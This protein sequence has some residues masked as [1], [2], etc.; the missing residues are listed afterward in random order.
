M[1]TNFVP[2]AKKLSFC[3]NIRARTP[4][5]VSRARLVHSW[6]LLVYVATWASLPKGLSCFR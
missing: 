6:Q 5:K 1:V 2:A 4:L 3:G